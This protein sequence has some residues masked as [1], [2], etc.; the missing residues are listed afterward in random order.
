MWRYLDNQYYFVVH[1]N[2]LLWVGLIAFVVAF[3]AS[4]LVFRNQ[5][6]HPSWRLGVPGLCVA[7][8]VT[9]I[10]AIAVT[11]NGCHEVRNCLP[12]IERMMWAFVVAVLGLG[13]WIGYAA[14]VF[15]VR[16]RA[17]S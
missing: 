11:L 7:L 10:V 17:R 12:G 5:T 13:L 14:A 2:G 6:V 9:M 8:A 1:W 16:H 15:F 3:V 4:L